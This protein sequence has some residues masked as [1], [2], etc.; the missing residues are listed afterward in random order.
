MKLQQDWWICP[1]LVLPTPSVF[2]LC[3]ITP[4]LDVYLFHALLPLAIMAADAGAKPA[5]PW[6]VKR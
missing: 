6:V 4:S 3:G 1:E 2:G 5:L